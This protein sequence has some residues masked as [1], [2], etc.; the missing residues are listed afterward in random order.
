MSGMISV[1]STAK[2]VG[3]PNF[4]FPTSLNACPSIFRS[5]VHRTTSHGTFG[6]SFGVISDTSAILLEKL[7][8]RECID[9]G[10]GDP[11][12]NDENED[13]LWC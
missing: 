6:D 11:G 9:E 7:D 1:R 2:A 4:R 3:I 5:L 10:E 8:T 13:S 12:G